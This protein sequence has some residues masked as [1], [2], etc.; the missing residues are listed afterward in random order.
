MAYRPKTPVMEHWTSLVFSFIFIFI[1]I[2][3]IVM[4]WGESILSHLKAMRISQWWHD[5]YKK[6]ICILDPF[7]R[8]MDACTSKNLLGNNDGL[9]L[10]GFELGRF[11]NTACVLSFGYAFQKSVRGI[12]RQE[13]MRQSPTYKNRARCVVPF[14][15][16]SRRYYRYIIPH[17]F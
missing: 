15:F 6:Y 11:P 4:M 2:F 8:C 5:I 3:M 14:H 7:L 17:L 12:E 13:R 10:W 9:N 16:K 1:F